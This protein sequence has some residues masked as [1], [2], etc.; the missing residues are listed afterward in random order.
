[1]IAKYHQLTDQVDGM[2]DER[3]KMLSDKNGLKTAIADAENRERELTDQLNALTSG[4][5][6]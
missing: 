1:L 6:P 5:S 3:D 2:K 4:E